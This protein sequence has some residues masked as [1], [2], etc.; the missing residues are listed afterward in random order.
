M[1]A[2]FGSAGLP[3]R[4]PHADRPPPTATLAIGTTLASLHRLGRRPCCTGNP[5]RN[6]VPVGP[7]AGRSRHGRTPVHRAPRIPHPPQH[8]QAAARLAHRPR[9]DLPWPAPDAPQPPQHA[10]RGQVAVSPRTQVARAVVL[11]G[12]NATALWATTFP[13]RSARVEANVCDYVLKSGM[14]DGSQAFVS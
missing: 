7:P 4:T 14:I 3:I 5:R 6:A 13:T 1:H 11:W 12:C 9:E 2:W 10:Q 8:R